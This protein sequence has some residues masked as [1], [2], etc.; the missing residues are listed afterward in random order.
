MRQ[1]K[2]LLTAVAVIGVI[3]EVLE[4]LALP[5]LFVVCG[6]LNGYGWQYY[7]WTI[8]GYVAL[9]AAAE[10]TGA[11]IGKLLGRAFE[12]RLLRKL[13]RNRPA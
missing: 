10:L 11:M 7:A 4:Y 2:R 5:V 1:W 6:L 9:L 3:G 12:P 13:R 8:G